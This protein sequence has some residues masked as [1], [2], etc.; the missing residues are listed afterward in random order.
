M[1][2]VNYIFFLVQSSKS[3]IKSLINSPSLIKSPTNCSALGS[4]S[5]DNSDIYSLIGPVKSLREDVKSSISLYKKIIHEISS[6]SLKISANILKKLLEPLN[7]SSAFWKLSSGEGVFRVYFGGSYFFISC[8][9]SSI[10]FY[11]FFDSF[12]LYYKG[13]AIAKYLN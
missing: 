8:F 3:L 4:S 13:S 12:L 11:S 7:V 5:A 10:I 6:F 2:T 1:K 9:F